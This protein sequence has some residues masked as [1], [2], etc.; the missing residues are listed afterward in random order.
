VEG[1][2]DTVAAIPYVWGMTAMALA[3]VFLGAAFHAARSLAPSPVKDRV[4]AAFALATTAFVALALS[5]ELDREFLSVAIAA[6]LLAVTWV[7][8]RV[9]IPALRPIAALL[10][11][12]FAFLLAPQ[13]LLLC[14]LAIYSVFDWW[15][16]GYQETLPIV[17][18]PHFQLALPAGFFLA[19][20][21]LLRKER[22]DRFVRV[23]EGAAIALVALWGFYVT[24]K[25]FHPGENVLYAKATFLERGM[26]TSVLF[27]Y[28]L[29]CLMIGRLYARPV[30][31]WSGVLLTAIALFR[32]IWFDLLV[33]NPAWYH[34]EVPG[35]FLFNAL[36]VTYLLPI[37]WIWAASRE[38][39]LISHPWVSRSIRWTPGLMLVLAFAWLSLE[40]RRLYQGPFLD[41]ARMTDAELYTYS[42]VWLVFGLAL[43]FFGTLRASQM[44]RF[45]SLAV[46]LATVSKVFLIDAG[47]LTGLYRVFSFLGLGLSLLGLSYFYSRFVFGKPP[48]E[49]ETPS[50]PTP[51]A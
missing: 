26:I 25:L 16:G 36:A 40:I 2:R 11:L 5:V 19:A 34:I 18:Y 31:A 4:L 45:A 44:L 32:V 46:M 22:D 1:V 51:A 3:L 29:V 50:A 23:L 24:S 13:I 35:A 38:L 48:P 15:W 7:A 17:D 37:A 30:F 43:L 6:E 28:G 14:Q 49:E 41:G 39:I 47:N 20:A 12:V 10:G 21:W 33:R 8:G 9:N 27:L 42:V